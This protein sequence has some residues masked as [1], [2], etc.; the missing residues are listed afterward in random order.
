MTIEVFDPPGAITIATAGPH[1]I[2][3]PYAT[4]AIT[5]TIVTP[6]SLVV[7]L[8]PETDFTVS[9]AE[10]LSG[11]GDL[12]LEAGIFAL[13]TGC[14]LY[15]DRATSLEQGWQGQMTREKG[16]EA[17]LDAGVMAVQELQALRARTLRSI[18]PMAPI[19]PG[20]DGAVLMW[21]SG[22][23][24]AGPTATEISGA[25]QAAIDAEIARDLA[26]AAA[27]TI[28]WRSVAGAAALAALSFGQY[29]AAHVQ[30]LAPVP[31]IWQAADYSG[32]IAAGDPR[33]VAPDS[34]P[35]GG[36][37]A[38]VRAWS[39]VNAWAPPKWPS[40]SG[41]LYSGP[42]A[43]VVHRTGGWGSY[44]LALLQLSVDDVLPTGELDSV[45]TAWGSAAN[46]TGGTIFGGWIGANSP[47]SEI[48][49]HLWTAGAVVGLEV[50]SGNRDRELG[51]QADYG[52]QPCWTVGMQVVPDVSPADGMAPPA[53]IYHGTFGVTIHQ[54]I[55]G[56]KW[57][58]G[59]LTAVDAVVPGGMGF[60]MRGGSVL[61]NAPGHALYL[62]GY[63]T[64]GIVIAGSLTDAFAITGAATRAINLSGGT[65]T[66][67]IR[68]AIGQGMSW[69]SGGAQLSTTGGSLALS[70]GNADDDFAVYANNF[71]T[72]VL[73][74]DATGGVARIAFNGNTPV[75]KAILP[76]A[77][78]DL[79]T[80][81]TLLNA[82]R[83]MNINN[84]L[85][86]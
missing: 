62:D 23:L 63:H 6:D 59:W 51:Y 73:S 57:H 27:A 76:A 50:N 75:P 78:T 80:A 83:T 25:Q 5:A 9:P 4:G 58:T 60:R 30:D 11:A 67:A 34:D 26:Q 46:Q 81:L 77:A 53:T 86:V 64:N 42:I 18:Q 36:T 24:I 14:Q 13:Y 70:T 16:L 2:P 15:I 79:A 68:M 20:D 8:N 19:A 33:F 56:H 37:G 29:G 66:T 65:F 31:Y 7:V 3:F 49:G 35:T 38:W 28:N 17:Q 21:D 32:R 40:V 84:G 1:E 55:W 43:H 54:S 45:I 48:P 44:G 22:N 61:A 72:R 39:M 52:A 10:N 71:L 82:M 85:G 12:T 47:N 69:G 74:A 41:S